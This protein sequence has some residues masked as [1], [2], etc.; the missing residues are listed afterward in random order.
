MPEK[1]KEKY[2][3]AGVEWK[4]WVDVSF[5]KYTN[6]AFDRVRQEVRV[7]AFWYIIDRNAKT[8]KRIDELFDYVEREIQ[9][10]NSSFWL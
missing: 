5:Q 3:Q 9:E 7:L 1:A 2:R 8:L 10:Q 6:M 4:Q